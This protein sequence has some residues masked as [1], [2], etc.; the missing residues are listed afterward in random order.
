MGDQKGG[1]NGLKIGDK[2]GGSNGPKIGDKKG[3]SNGPKIGDKKVVWIIGD[4]FC[5]HGKRG[6]LKCLFC[7]KN[8]CFEGYF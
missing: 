5:L 2:K 1:S 8:G 4:F 7:P 3:G 6:L